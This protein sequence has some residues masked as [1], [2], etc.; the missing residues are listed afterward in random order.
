[1]KSLSLA[2]NKDMQESHEGL[3][4][5][6]D[7]I[8]P[9]LSIFA[10]MLDT[11]AW[12]TDKMYNSALGGYTNATDAADWL[13]KQGM[14]FRE[15]HEVIGKLVNYA[16]QQGKRLDELSLDEF[17]RFSEVFDDSVFNAISVEQCVKARGIS[18]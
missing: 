12:G 3:Y 15:A 14:P 10:A 11:A 1:M 4:D 6:I 8:K 7:T 16:A 13:V 17:R 9:C 5:A 2:Y 18:V